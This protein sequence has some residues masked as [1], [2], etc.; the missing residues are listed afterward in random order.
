MVPSKGVTSPPD[1]EQRKTT[2]TRISAMQRAHRPVTRAVL[3][4]HGVPSPGVGVVAQQNGVG[5]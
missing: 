1:N 5:T 4:F 2:Q 3:R